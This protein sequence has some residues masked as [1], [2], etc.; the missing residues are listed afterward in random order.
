MPGFVAYCVVAIVNLVS[1]YFFKDT[2]RKV[3]KVALMP[4]LLVFYLIAS[5][6]VIWM[7]VVALIASWIGDIVL[8]SDNSPALFLAGLVAF[9]VGHLFYIS[10]YLSLA[11]HIRV[12]PLILSLLVG[13][14]VVIAYIRLL[15][16]QG[17][18]RIP[19]SAYACVITLMSLT[20]LQVLV[21]R[22]G[23]ATAILFASSVVFVF[24]DA[25]MG[26]L[27]F[28]GQPKYYYVITMIPY[29]LAQGGIVMGLVL[30]H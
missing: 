1:A 2:V 26:Y 22:P 8:M 6:H 30:C 25:L 3:A 23:V 10:T 9:L 15:K 17:A 21:A 28:H 12:V 27:V 16:P 29:I 14:L 20:A 7:V 13:T 5:T 24:S 11:G 18:M 4:T 19:S